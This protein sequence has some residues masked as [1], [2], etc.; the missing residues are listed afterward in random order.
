MPRT[1]KTPVPGSDLPVIDDPE[2]LATMVD[3]KR[4]DDVAAAAVAIFSDVAADAPPDEP[5]EV[6]VVNVDASV[7]KRPVILKLAR[8]MGS[9]P[10][11]LPIGRNA[12]FGYNFIK[13]TQ[14]SGAVRPRMAREG[15]MLIP[16]VLSEEWVETKTAKGGIS[17]VTK[18]HVQF[19]IID[20]ESGDSITG[21]AYG[22]GDDAGDKGANKALTAAEKYFLLKLFQIGG[23][24]LEDDSRADQ[25]AADRAAGNQ[26]TMIQ[27]GGQAQNVQR[28]GQQQT[29]SATQLR[30]IGAVYATLREKKGWTPERFVEFIDQTLGDAIDLPEDPEQTGAAI[31]AYLK[32]LT[33]DDA[34]KLITALQDE[35][36]K[37][38]EDGPSGGYPG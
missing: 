23:E 2:Q 29:I 15:L 33:G 21:S 25:R 18:L 13:D 19:T 7:A 38:T 22:Y 11:L 14:V 34:G 1:A 4:Q 3:P 20:S 8:I 27:N 26:P 9:L 16:N 35:K 28:G 12:H 30:V 31:N 10:T 37:D 24:D 5:F 36:D 17:Y 6:T 32:Q